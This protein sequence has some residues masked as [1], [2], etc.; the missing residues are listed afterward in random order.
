MGDVPALASEIDA[1]CKSRIYH[2]SARTRRATSDLGVQV[3]DQALLLAR[4]LHGA[5]HIQITSHSANLRVTSLYS[6]N[7]LP[8]QLS[9]AHSERD[10]TAQHELAQLERA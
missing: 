9:S 3:L 5:A 7:K 10:A 4:V 1:R 2:K 6:L 8:L